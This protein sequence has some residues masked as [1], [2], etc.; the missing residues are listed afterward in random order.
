MS[1]DYF[2]FLLQTPSTEKEWLQVAAGFENRLQ[3]P[4]C[5]GSIDGKHI[6]IKKPPN[7]GTMFYNYKHYFSIAMMAVVDSNYEFLYVSSGC[8][9]ST[10][11]GGHW[12]NTDFKASIDDG[13]HNLPGFKTLEGVGNIPYHFTADDA[14]QMTPRLMKPYSVTDMSVPEDVFCYRLSRARMVVENAFG[15]IAS[16]FRVLQGTINMAPEAA[17]TIVLAICALHNMLRVTLGKNYIS[18]SS[19]DHEDG[20]NRIPIS[21][22][23]RKNPENNISSIKRTMSRN[24]SKEAKEIRQKLTDYFVSTPGIVDWQWRRI[25]KSYVGFVQNVL[26]ANNA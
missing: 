22:T 5:L 10:A 3:Y 25:N 2:L 1:Y 21:G 12:Q 4:A 16:R 18:R 15:I 19:Y 6:R 23:W 24:A 17:E 7:S 9:G 8:E 11:D 20:E 14:F 13:S 26:N